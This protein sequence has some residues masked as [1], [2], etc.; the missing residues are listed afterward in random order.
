[1]CSFQT[2]LAQYT[3]ILA[4]LR[5]AH[6]SASRPKSANS[7]RGKSS[8]W[9]T[10]RLHLEGTRKSSSAAALHAASQGGS[11]VEFDTTL[12]V[13]P[14]GESA[15]RASYWVHVDN[16]MNLEILVLQH[17]SHYISAVGAPSSLAW[18]S[19]KSSIQGSAPGSTAKEP[20][21][22]QTENYG[23]IVCDD[24]QA[25]AK[26]RGSETVNDM[27]NSPGASN[28]KAIASIR[29]SKADDTIV[30]LES[31][32]GS[33]AK[34]ASLQTNAHY[35]QLKMKKKEI[36]KL[37]H[38][39]RDSKSDYIKSSKTNLAKWLSDNP[40]VQPFFSWWSVGHT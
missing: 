13:I 33:L 1:M 19:S 11:S 20:V 36:R 34:D 12:A 22:H 24:L 35:E 40:K 38:L 2:L 6:A 32:N 10:P 26:R 17:A 21:P 31:M 9:P 16:I 7:S 37:F 27:E 5:K 8:G 18:N 29:F 4:A 25:F 28:E 3:E 23:L 14:L 15:A 30:S 39:G